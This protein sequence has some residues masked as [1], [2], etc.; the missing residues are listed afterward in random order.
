MKTGTY[1]ITYMFEFFLSLFLFSH[2]LTI[3]PKLAL[4]SLEH[5]SSGV[6][7]RRAPLNRLGSPRKYESHVVFL[8]PAFVRLLGVITA[9]QTQIRTNVGL[10]IASQGN[11]LS[12]RTQQPHMLKH[13]RPH[14]DLILRLLCRKRFTQRINPTPIS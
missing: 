11:K 14:G 2:P 12:P 1:C 10:Y 9:H 8:H 13:P 6:S 3:L 5:P 4:L 7:K